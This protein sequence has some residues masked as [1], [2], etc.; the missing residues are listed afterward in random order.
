MVRFENKYFSMKSLAVCIQIF[1]LCIASYLSFAQNEL[2][3]IASKWQELKRVD[4]RNNEISFTDTMR[5]EIRADGFM[6]LRYDNGPTIT[7]E[8]EWKKDELFLEEITFQV[9]HYDNSTLELKSKNYTHTLTK[10]VEF[11]SRPVVKIIPGVEHGLVDLAMKTMQGKWT[12]YK[13]TDPLFDRTKFY[14]KS[15]DVK[16]W[17][18][19]DSIRAEIVY[20]S[21]DSI[22]SY[23]ATLQ[24]KGNNVI[25]V[26]QK[27]EHKLEALKSD[28]EELILKDGN[29]HYFM[30]QFGRQEK[31]K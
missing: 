13:K 25:V 1:F 3:K 16:E 8:V 5:M 18:A 2:H 7:G 24:I 23:N 6:M 29:I 28:G 17:K 30:K 31:E 9:L 10:S 11:Q 21:N 12:C 19:S 22:Y 27:N 14:I 20:Q 26:N 4:K 15:L